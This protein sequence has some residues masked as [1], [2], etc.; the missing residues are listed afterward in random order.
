MLNSRLNR[1]PVYMRNTWFLNCEAVERAYEFPSPQNGEGLAVGSARRV[2]TPDPLS[3]SGERIRIISN[4]PTY[5]SASLRSERPSTTPAE[6]RAGRIN[7]SAARANNFHGPRRIPRD[8]RAT[9]RSSTTAAKLCARRLIGVAACAAQRGAR[10]RHAWLIETRIRTRRGGLRGRRALNCHDIKG[11]VATPS[12]K[13]CSSGKARAAPGACHDGGSINR[14]ARHAAETAALRRRQARRR[15]GLELGLNDLL[16]RVGTNFD[17]SLVITITGMSHAQHV[18][19]RWNCFQDHAARSADA[20]MPL[21]IDVD[22]GALRRHDDHARLALLRRYRCVEKGIVKIV[23]PFTDIS[24]TP[25]RL[26]FQ[27]AHN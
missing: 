5:F 22:F 10:G 1:A 18:L 17:N 14:N 4:N 15:R 24:W 2:V 21:V 20:P 3:F 11:R 27:R 13:L 25:F 23:E 9:E 16:I 8:R 26:A 6:F 12:A 7:G 19:S